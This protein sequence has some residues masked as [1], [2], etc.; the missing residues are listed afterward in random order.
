MGMFD[1]VN[2]EMPCPKC[3]SPL[4]IFQSKDNACRMWLIPPD[5]VN[6][7][8]TSCDNCKTWIEFSRQAPDVSLEKTPPAT[9]EQVEA[10]GFKCN[11]PSTDQSLEEDTYD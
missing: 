4:D 3:G 2:V 10:L 11:I 9:R 5:T 1:Y 7:F 6:V 8:Y